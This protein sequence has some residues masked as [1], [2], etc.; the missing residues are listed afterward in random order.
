MHAHLVCVMMFVYACL[1]YVFFPFMIIIIIT[2]TFIYKAPCFRNR[3]SV[4]RRLIQHFHAYNK[5]LK[6]Y[7][8]IAQVLTWQPWELNR[9]IWN[10][11]TNRRSTTDWP[12]M[13]LVREVKTTTYKTIISLYAPQIVRSSFLGIVTSLTSRLQTRLILIQIYSIS[14]EIPKTSNS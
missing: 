11:S 3:N 2:M 14:H 6:A 5:T 12:I 8:K 4:Q 7:Y 1:S 9:G 13:A 10:L